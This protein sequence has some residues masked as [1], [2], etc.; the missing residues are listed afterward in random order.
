M[1]ERI[2]GKAKAAGAAVPG[3]VRYDT[4]VTAAQIQ[5]TATVVRK[6]QAA[7]DVRDLWNELKNIGGTRGIR[8]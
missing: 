2:E 7:D 5:A 4:D 1:A 6:C 3:R 8:F